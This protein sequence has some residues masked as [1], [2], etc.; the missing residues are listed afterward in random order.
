MSGDRTSRFAWLSISEGCENKGNLLIEYALRKLLNIKKPGLTV[1]AFS[2]MSEDA[3]AGVN[4]SQL[5]LLPGTT[6]LDPREYP[7]LD[8]LD[9][10]TCNKLAIGVAF[11]ARNGN[12]D[13]SVARNINLPIGSRDPFTHR[14]LRAASIE[15]SFVG[16]PTLF[17]GNATK[18]KRKDGPLI[19]S[20]GP[21][22]QR[23]LQECVHA[24]AAFDDVILLEHVPRLQPRF[25]LPD[26]IRRVE[27]RSASQAIKLYSNA[28]AVLT[29][30]LHAYLTCLSLGVPATFFTSWY[31]SRFSLLEH[32]GIELEAAEPKR[33]VHVVRKM[34]NGKSRSVLSLEKAEKLRAAMIKYLKKLEITQYSANASSG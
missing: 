22:P 21:G 31:D 23:E 20:L 10:I 13:L 9:R 2:P 12:V 19:I 1:S 18:W 27:I 5:L 29:G 26:R 14:Q 30:R 3:I 24:C 15:S 34:L 28:S 6:L 33:I 4:S 8:A 25:P 11:C 7:A 17:I 16:C 32:L